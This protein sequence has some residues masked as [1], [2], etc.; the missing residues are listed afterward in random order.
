MAF[1]ALDGGMGGGAAPTLSNFSVA[2]TATATARFSPSISL[3]QDD[4]L[5][6]ANR[7]LDAGLQAYGHVQDEEGDARANDYI[8]WMM[9][10]KSDY[11]HLINDDALVNADGADTLQDYNSR[12]MEER[13]SITDGLSARARKRFE[14]RVAASER[15]WTLSTQNH[16]WEQRK[17]SSYIK[18]QNGQENNT[19]LAISALT[20]EG[21][22][23]DSIDD[24]INDTA[25][26]QRD[27]WK[28]YGGFRDG[29]HL[30]KL[31]GHNMYKQ[32]EYIANVIKEKNPDAAKKL[33]EKYKNIFPE[34][35]Y[36]KIVAEAVSADEYKAGQDAFSNSAKN[37]VIEGFGSAGNISEAATSVIQSLKG[38]K[39]SRNAA[40]RNDCSST[41][42]KIIQASDMS[43]SDKKLFRGGNSRS[44]EAALKKRVGQNNSVLEAGK[45]KENVIITM[46]TGK[47][48]FDGGVEGAAD[49]IAITIRG[50][51]GKIYVA[52]TTGSGSK[53]TEYSKWKS[54]Q[55]KGADFRAFDI[56]SM[57]GKGKSTGV[58]QSV[59]FSQMSYGQM[60]ELCKKYYPNRGESFYKGFAEMAGYKAEENNE[61]KR[62]E[63]EQ[64]QEWLA[65]EHHRLAVFN[66][67][68]AREY[69]IKRE[70][71]RGE[72][73]EPD[74]AEYDK[75]NQ[76]SEVDAEAYSGWLLVDPDF[77]NRS[78]DNI[79]AASGGHKF[80]KTVLMDEYNRRNNPRKAMSW[81]EPLTPEE[82]D[83]A[84]R[85]L[86]YTPR[87]MSANE[88][89]RI[90]TMVTQVI[91]MRHN[92]K[93]RKMYPTYKEAMDAWVKANPQSAGSNWLANF[94]VSTPLLGN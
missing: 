9:K 33:M 15:D 23:V 14:E 43:A 22:D 40:D 61:R 75:V 36:T 13:S 47:K 28:T 82:K 69:A 21:R 27:Y 68:T 35:E 1:K 70:K 56:S 52:E 86:G 73:S 79:T 24:Y 72:L 74:R 80:L 16:Q 46:D 59:D 58:R 71:A 83:Y 38:K 60:I 37:N 7:L 5:K 77:G 32:V 44:M 63:A 89:N 11:K 50:N 85:V 91:K 42:D 66:A 65:K 88:K 31:I 67:E 45:I 4:T 90:G 26:I 20:E 17:N 30:D 53:I 55:R 54:S 64:R 87:N 10:N 81:Y 57:L 6:Y 25:R 8:N 12:R 34:A 3:R 62:M 48:S 39:Y 94:Y 84:Y 19:K 2:P 78:I 51:D 41:I 92:A 76:K 93:G 29:E 18:M 49:H